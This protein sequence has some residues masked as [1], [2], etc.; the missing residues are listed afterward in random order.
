MVALRAVLLG[1]LVVGCFGLEVAALN[2]DPVARKPR[3]LAAI[4]VGNNASHVRILYESDHEVDFDVWWDAVDQAPQLY[5]RRGL[6]ANWD[7]PAVLDLTGL[8]V[9]ASYYGKFYLPDGSAVPFSFSTRSARITFL[10][11][12]RYVEDGDS[13]M[14]AELVATQSDLAVHLGDQVYLDSVARSVSES[15]TFDELVD[16]IRAVYRTTW[17]QP[18]FQKFLLSRRNLMIPDDH[19]VLNNLDAETARN[20]RYKE[21]IRAAT[22]VYGQYQEVDDVVAALCA[23]PCLQWCSP[24]AGFEARSWEAHL[25][26]LATQFESGPARVGYAL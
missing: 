19:D 6:H 4:G 26:V 11:C 9:P 7:A 25:S 17:M 16:R 2:D 3:L 13:D 18:V 10:S 23:F 20:L 14:F 1:C 24:C 15:D 22:F 12:N 5:T 21:F 8:V